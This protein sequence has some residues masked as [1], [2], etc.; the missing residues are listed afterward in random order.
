MDRDRRP[1]TE[2]DRGVQEGEGVES[3]PLDE[4]NEIYREGAA[5]TPEDVTPE[6]RGVFSNL[7]VRLE[8]HTYFLPL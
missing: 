1:T 7:G 2:P 5:T 3:N 4:L 6:Q 8:K